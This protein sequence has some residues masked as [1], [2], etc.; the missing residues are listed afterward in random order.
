MDTKDSKVNNIYGSAGSS[1]H[2]SSMSLFAPMS[3]NELLKSESVRPGDIVG[4]IYT[5][6][7]G[8]DVALEEYRDLMLPKLNVEQSQQ[9]QLY[10]VPSKNHD[11][12]QIME[13]MIE[14]QYPVYV[15]SAMSQYLYNR[16][17]R[18]IHTLANVGLG[19]DTTMT[20]MMLTRN[21]PERKQLVDSLVTFHQDLL[22]TYSEVKD[23]M[24]NRLAS[25]NKH[26]FLRRSVD[27]KDLD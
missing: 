26:A 24:T 27:K 25:A 17:S 2:T 10:C 20:N 4:Q 8:M 5:T 22:S 3:I 18:I 14:S 15:A 9:Y 1:A 7:M 23:T 19:V 6:L 12:L 11:M 16:E 21:G 13:V